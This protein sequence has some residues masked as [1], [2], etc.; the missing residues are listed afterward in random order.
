M[1]TVFMKHRGPRGTHGLVYGLFLSALL[2]AS[3]ASVARAETFFTLRE[4]LGSHFHDSTQV[5]YERVHP[6]ADVRAAI[7]RRTGSAPKDEYVVYVARSGE[8][9][10][11][12]AL[13][14]QERGQHEL[15]DIATFFDAQGQVTDVEVMTYREAYGEAIRSTRFRQQFVGR[16]AS[17]GFAAGRD[18]DIISGA[19]LSSGAMARAVARAALL[20]DVARHQPDTLAHR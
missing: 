3:V 7:Q 10:D 11:G 19:T 13:F 5:G 6:A 17:S 9:V 14:D 1:K 20:V 16:D 8:H 2:T 4:L 15:I 12:Y 18:V